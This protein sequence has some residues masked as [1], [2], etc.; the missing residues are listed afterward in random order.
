MAIIVLIKILI[1]L[2]SQSLYVKID[3]KAFYKK[4]IAL[5]SSGL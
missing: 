2:K 5:V 4:G 3:T 1:A